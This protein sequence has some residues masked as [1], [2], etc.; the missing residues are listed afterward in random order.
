MIESD[1][2]RGDEP[3]LRAVEQRRVAAR[4]GSDD[5]RIGVMHVPGRDRVARKAARLG[6]RLENS[7]EERNGIIDN[8]FHLFTM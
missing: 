4:A 3:H 2:R 1:G 8:D 6:V 7:L 5:E